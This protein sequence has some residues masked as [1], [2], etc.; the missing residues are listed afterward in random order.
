MNLLLNFSHNFNVNAL[1]IVLVHTV[2]VGHPY[3]ME[4]LTAPHSPA[5]NM[6]MLKFS[7]VDSNR[8][9]TSTP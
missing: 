2:R 7:F 1:K 6:M 8:N 9:E 4:T 3:H 5:S